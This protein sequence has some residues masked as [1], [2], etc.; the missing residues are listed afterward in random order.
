MN[1]IVIR[2]SVASALATTGDKLSGINTRRAIHLALTPEHF[3]E[4]TVYGLFF[5]G[6]G[7]KLRPAV[8]PPAS[9]R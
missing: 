1:P 4:R 9:V 8:A 3:D 2:G 5:L 7:T 6:A